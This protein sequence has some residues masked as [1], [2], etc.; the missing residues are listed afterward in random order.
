MPPVKAYLDYHYFF[1]KQPLRLLPLRRVC[2][3]EADCLHGEDEA[4]CPQHVPEG[5]QA[6]GESRAPYKSPARSCC[7]EPPPAQVR[8]G[9]R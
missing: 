7:C 9:Q 2:D 4:S 6:G 8:P 5:P 1:C 3:G